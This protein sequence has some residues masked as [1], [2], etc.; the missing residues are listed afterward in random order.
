MLI[1][2]YPV[3]LQSVTPISLVCNVG[4]SAPSL[5][6]AC[7]PSAHAGCVS[8]ALSPLLARFAARSQLT[9]CDMQWGLWWRAGDSQWWAGQEIE[10]EWEQDW[11]EAKVIAVEQGSVNVDYV[12]GTQ[13]ER[14]WIET[15]SARLRVPLVGD[16][17]SDED[18]ESSHKDQETMPR[19]IIGVR[20]FPGPHA[21]GACDMLNAVPL[22]VVCNLQSLDALAKGSGVPRKG[23]YID[24]GLVQQHSDKLQG[25]ARTT[26]RKMWREMQKCGEWADECARFKLS[27]DLPEKILE[28][29]ILP[30][31]PTSAET[32]LAR[33]MSVHYSDKSDA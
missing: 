16:D 10:V 15:S 13:D 4:I 6:R 18:G 27:D 17:C 14:E 21:L 9:R 23:A 22:K 26:L 25:I 33:M 11:W 3:C 12:G 30:V 31:L 19:L 20:L 1:S 7:S 2:D 29:P 28:V 8:L 24:W 32:A 5:A